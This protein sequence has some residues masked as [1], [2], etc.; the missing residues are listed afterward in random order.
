MT[1]RMIE[2]TWILVSLIEGFKGDRLFLY[3]P[4]VF[5]TETQT[6][7]KTDSVLT[8]VSKISTLVGK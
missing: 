3:F 1:M 4:S 6:R 8:I 7:M 5:G 2:S